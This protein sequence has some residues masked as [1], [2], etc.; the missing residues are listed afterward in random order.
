MSPTDRTIGVVTGGAGSL[1][2]A[3]ARALALAADHLLLT[4]LSEE[5]LA[6][7][8][9]DMEAEDLSVS[10]A[11]CD[12][13][14]AKQVA[15][16]VEQA[17][18]LGRLGALVHTA[19]LSGAMGT[20]TEVL[21]ANLVGSLHVLDGF[22]PLVTEGSVGV[23][24]ASIGGH[25]SLARQ[26]DG[27]LLGAHPDEIMSVLDAAGALQFNSRVAYAISKRGLILET[28]RRAR[29]WGERGGRLVSVSPGLIADSNMGGLVES[30][31][32]ESR[33]YA[34]RSA[35]GRPG[36]TRDI[37]GVVGFL[38]SPAAAYVTGTDVLVD[39]GVLAHHDHHLEPVPRTRWHVAP[40]SA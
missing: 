2:G 4:D 38:C 22:E 17:A 40:G 31:G 34:T 10:T 3:C 37:A 26:Y 36:S 20:A 27:L 21:T 39:G 25:R 18:A 15:A 32:G 1:G 30:T 8:A 5:R 24:I 7:A 35:I 28:Q 16:L 12:V 14:D 6:A 33:A 13:T 11:V 29:A 23:M 9:A 19:G